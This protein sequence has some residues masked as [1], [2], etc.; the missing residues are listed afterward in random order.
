MACANF[1]SWNSIGSSEP[2]HSG[3]SNWVESEIAIFNTVGI[4]TETTVGIPT[5]LRVKM[6][7]LMRLF[8]YFLKNIVKLFTSKIA[9]QT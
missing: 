5:G 7:L 2:T 8:Q 6:C 4:P 1:Y 9:N 3:Y